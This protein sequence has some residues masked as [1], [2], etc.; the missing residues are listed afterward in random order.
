MR[1]IRFAALTL[2]LAGALSPFAQASPPVQESTV[3]ADSAR[4]RVKFLPE[5]ALDRIDLSGKASPSMAS[6][7]SGTEAEQ[8]R[9]L[10]GRSREL[11]GGC[12]PLP[13][14]ESDQPGEKR[15]LTLDQLARSADFAV[16]GTVEQI[17]PGW[18]TQ[19]IRPATLVQLHVSEVLFDRNRRARGSASLSYLQ[20]SGS[21]QVEGTKICSVDPENRAAV[22]GRELL[23]IGVWDRQNPNVAQSL[24]T[25]AV[26]GDHVELPKDAQLKPYLERDPEGSLSRLRA[27]LAEA[28]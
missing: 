24:H 16:L 11:K 5:S 7:L 2:C 28:H 4:T 23:V 18:S 14:F 10:A 3:W 25:F 9:T 22:L 1:S 15:K 17:V 27:A 13:R 19:L 20:R 8:I 6:P 26:A 21:I 12:F